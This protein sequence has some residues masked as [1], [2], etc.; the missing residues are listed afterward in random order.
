MFQNQKR[1]RDVLENEGFLA[2]VSLTTDWGL[3]FF[4]DKKKK[5]KKRQGGCSK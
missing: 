5:K 4:S 3:N 1:N 2:I